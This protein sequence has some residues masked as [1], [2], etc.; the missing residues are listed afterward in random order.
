MVIIGARGLGKEVLINTMFAGDIIQKQRTYLS[1]LFALDDDSVQMAQAKRLLEDRVINHDICLYDDKNP[2]TPDL[3]YDR[4]KVIR[5][6]EEAK[7]YIQGVDNRFICA[8]GQ[9]RLRKKLVDKF[10][11]VSGQWVPSISPFSNVSPIN[12]LGK[13]IITQPG[14]G[15]TNDVIVGDGV[16]LLSNSLIGHDAILGNYVSISPN[17]TILGPCEIGDFTTIGAGSVI[18][19]NVSIGKHAYIAAGTVIDQDVKDYETVTRK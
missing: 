6:F 13:G 16:I 1:N 19:H 18:L 2:D 5:D 17:V 10:L 15:I 3:I 12:Q 4:Y 7:A 8:I 11:A 9:P 14:S